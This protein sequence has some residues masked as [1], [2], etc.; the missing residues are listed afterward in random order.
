MKCLNEPIARQANAEDH[1]TGH[2]WEARFQSQ[3]LRSER[4]LLA[5]MAY[6]DLNP[7]RARMAPTP[8]DSDFTSIRVRIRGDDGSRE[9]RGPVTRMLER[10]E[11]HHFEIPVRPLLPFSDTTNP[12]DESRSSADALPMRASDY[13]NLVDETGRLLVTG[14]RGRIDA[15]VAP[16][17]GRLGF[18]STEWVR[19]SSGFRR[20]YRNGDLHLKPT[21]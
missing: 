11:L 2:F 9:Q 7:I 17:L 3:A 19:A 1:C 20:L 6:V 16:I 15:S 21:G 8:E 5:A 10:G 14:K 4:A 13:L 12:M 18:S